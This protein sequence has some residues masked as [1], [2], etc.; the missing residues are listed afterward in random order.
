MPHA[1]RLVTGNEEKGATGG[2]PLSIASCS[3]NMISGLASTDP[4]HEMLDED[5]QEELKGKIKQLES[6]LKSKR[7][8]HSAMLGNYEDETVWDME[9]T[10]YRMHLYWYPPGPYWLHTNFESHTSLFD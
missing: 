1:D 7:E 4:T 9:E 5:S 10:R 8:F 3:S 6:K 2:T